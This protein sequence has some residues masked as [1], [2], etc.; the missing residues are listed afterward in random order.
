MNK[1]TKKLIIS[2]FAL[3]IIVL[4]SST[5]EAQNSYM[6]NTNTNNMQ[7]TEYNTS[8]VT[9]NS[10]LNPSGKTT[11]AWFEYSTDP[12]F[13]TWNETEHEYVGSSN[14][15][16]PFGAIINNLSP[17]TVYYFRVIT[18]DGKST[19]K[20]NIL[21]FNTMGQNNN[22]SYN[23]SNFTN[24][25]YSATNTRYINQTQPTVYTN[26]ST[27]YQNTVPVYQNTNRTVNTNNVANPLFGAT[28]LPNTLGTWLVLLLLILIIAIVVKKLSRTTYVI[29][30]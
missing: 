24:T 29:Q 26:Q 5:A 12:N 18:N 10:S 7:Y 16:S 30:K 20:G 14:Q 19:I 8:S 23:N 11:T 22:V 17:N 3:S 1:N 28:F 9:L 15:E 2:L 27:N 6:T 21:S 13:R 25:N 4:S